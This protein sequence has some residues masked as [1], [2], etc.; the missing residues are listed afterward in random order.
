[1]NTFSAALT[2]AGVSCL[3]VL[4][5]RLLMPGQ[6]GLGS[7]FRPEQ[8]EEEGT[9][10]GGVFYLGAL[11]AGM[12]AGGSAFSGNALFSLLITASFILIGFAD[13]LVAMQDGRG[14]GIVPWLKA[15]LLLFVS[16]VAA[17]YLAFSNESGR[18]QCLPVCCASSDL[19]GWYLLLALPL[20]LLRSLAEK[21]LF[22]SAGSSFASEGYEAAFWCFVF[23]LA[24]ETGAVKWF[25]FRSEFY[26]MAVFSGSAA[27]AM[28]GLDLFNPGGQ[29]LRPG[30]GGYYGIG[31]SLALMA[32]CSCWMILLPLAALWPFVSAVYAFVLRVPAAGKGT[33]PKSYLLADFFLGRR[34][35]AERLRNTVR[36]ISLLGTLFAAVLYTI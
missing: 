19:K 1:M 33:A 17:V 31:A 13:E 6:S 21:P 18:T 14:E 12:V 26:G 4:V 29:A 28:L 5:L 7:L 10:L 20:L 25:G 16:V 23:A 9:R 35:T 22:E 30:T 15:A 34:M 11:I 2:A 3:T 8:P 24:G 27:G 36:W 32:L